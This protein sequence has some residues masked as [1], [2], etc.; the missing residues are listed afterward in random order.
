MIVTPSRSLMMPTLLPRACF[1]AR[2]LTRASPGDKT[3]P[4]PPPSYPWRDP[5]DARTIEFLSSLR[6]PYNVRTR[7]LSAGGQVSSRR[8]LAPWRRRRRR[9]A[10]KLIPPRNLSPTLPEPEQTPRRR[11]HISLAFIEVTESATRGNSSRHLSFPGPPRP[12]AYFFFR[13]FRQ[14][15][16]LR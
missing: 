6:K 4:F 13:F 10:T 1:L 5:A 15:A 3:V 12:P 7:F 16:S 9:P 11:W 8:R 2:A 14:A